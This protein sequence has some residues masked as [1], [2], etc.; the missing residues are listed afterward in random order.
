MVPSI[1]SR[2]SSRIMALKCCVPGCT[3]SSGIPRRLGCH[4]LPK[5]DVVAKVWLRIIKRNDMIGAPW[6]KLNKLKICG[7]HF[8]ENMVNSYKRKRLKN[9]AV[10]ILYLPQVDIVLNSVDTISNAID[11]AHLKNNAVPILY[12]PQVVVLNSVAT[13]SNA[14][15]IDNAGNI[16][17]N[18]VNQSVQEENQPINENQSV[19]EENQSTKEN[20][21]VQEKNQSQVDIAL[22]GVNDIYVRDNGEYVLGV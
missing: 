7:K 17:Y 15:S 16:D 20:Q 5:D 9:N 11:N 2:K 10:P 19:Q 21:S 3:S 14:M 13:I 22:S 18:L 1:S 4:G 8:P 6:Y 12:L